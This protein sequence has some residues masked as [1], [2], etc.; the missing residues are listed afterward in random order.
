MAD[1]KY[2]RLIMIVQ[3]TNDGSSTSITDGTKL[4]SNRSPE[5]LQLQ[6]ATKLK[7]FKPTVRPNQKADT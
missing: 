7:L 4:Q 5:Y 6:K 3:P 2:E 1:R